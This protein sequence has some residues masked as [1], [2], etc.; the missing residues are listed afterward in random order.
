MVADHNF[1]YVFVVVP[2]L[3]REVILGCDWLSNNIK[4]DFDR[5]CLAGPDKWDLSV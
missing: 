5:E 4:L 2:K 1:K 3:N